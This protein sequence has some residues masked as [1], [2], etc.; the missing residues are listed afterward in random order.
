MIKDYKPCKGFFDLSEKPKELNKKLY[1]KILDI[2]SY[3]IGENKHL[4]YYLKPYNN[5][6]LQ[7][8]QELSAKLQQ[9]ILHYWRLE[10][11]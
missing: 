4:D 7:Q 5:L 6:A 8:L 2:Q 10:A 11:I 1:A 9:I 3:L